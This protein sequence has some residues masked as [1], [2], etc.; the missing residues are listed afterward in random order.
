M[1]LTEVTKDT[2]FK[3]YRDMCSQL[4]LDVKGGRGKEFQL[5]E[6]DRYFTL[7]KKGNSL[8]VIS[9]NHTPLEKQMGQ[10]ELLSNAL[11]CYMKREYES[12]NNVLFM[13]SAY[14]MKILDMVNANYGKYKYDY[15]ALSEEIGVVVD[16]VEDFYKTVDNTFEKA[17]T[18]IMKVIQCHQSC[19]MFSKGTIVSVINNGD[20]SYRFATIEDSNAILKAEEFAYEIL[21]MHSLQDLLSSGM[22]SLF[23]DECYSY[24]RANY[25]NSIV[26]YFLGY[27]IV[28][29]DNISTLRVQELLP[30]VATPNA[31]VIEQQ[32]K[33]A[34][35]RHSRSINKH[36]FSRREIDKIRATEDYVEEQ[37]KIIKTVIQ[38]S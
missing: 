11:L 10:T 38:K 23:K 12:G 29:G 2:V 34:K 3:N 19:L 4:N 27:R 5:K 6:L 32:I 9:V 28:I 16:H 37:E 1:E 7:E 25:D 24:L 17:I 30:K 21:N 20:I 13:N 35:Q 15:K 22:Y 33:N 36:Y 26:S 14:A 8:I 31:N 18:R